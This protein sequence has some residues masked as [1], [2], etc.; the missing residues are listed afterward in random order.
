MKFGKNGDLMRK[1][2]LGVFTLSLGIII[3]AFVQP[4]QSADGVYGN[5]EKF[6]TVFN[7]AFRNYVE[8]VDAN[9][10]TEKA[11]EGMLSELDVHSVYIPPEQKKKVDEDF[12]GHFHGI[13]VQFDMLEDSI[14]V[15]SPLS[16]GPSQKLGIL[17]GDKIVKIDGENAVGIPRSDVPKRLK[18]PKGT[19]VTVDIYREGEEE[20]LHFEITRDKIPDWSLDSKFMLEGTDIGYMSFNRFSATTHEEMMKAVS[21]LSAQ[22]MKK[23]ILDLRGNPGGFLNQAYYMANEFLPKGDTIVYTNGRRKAFNETYISQT[24]GQLT[25]IPLIVLVDR[26][27][28]SASEIVSGSIQDLD[29]GIIAGETSFGKG[30][31]Q[32]QYPL[33]DGSAFRITISYYYTP[34]G[35][36]IQRPFKDKDKYRNLVGRLDLEEGFH[37][38][39]DDIKGKIVELMKE[40]KEDGE[41]EA[42][43]PDSLPIF[44]TKGGRTVFGGGGITPDYIVKRDTTK[45]QNMTVEY[46]KKRLMTIF[47]DK[48][49]KEDSGLKFREKY[50]NDFNAFYND[51]TLSNSDWEEFKEIGESKGIE[52]VEE[53]FEIDKSY[54]QTHI[55]ADIANIVWTRHESRKVWTAIDRQ[56]KNSIKLFPE[57]ERILSMN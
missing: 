57:A 2:I 38:N 21:E 10:L 47:A 16:G 5:L 27:S 13:G 30:L 9:A 29:R 26:G 14:T 32:R 40:N 7:T 8:D 41:E 25:D 4:T 22:G 49:L 3:G 28:A 1:V 53:D 37:F 42:F 52:W 55:K 11:I 24:N 19:L 46:R 20:L 33:E 23:M 44:Q 18:G 6:K 50:E 36:S 48:W 17:A 43:N 54:I 31:V 12:Q 39:Q 56:L 45:L 51:F 35:R 34:S 15:I